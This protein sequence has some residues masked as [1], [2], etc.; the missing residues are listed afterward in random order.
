[1]TV[2][3][4]CEDA[5][6]DKEKKEK[7]KQQQQKPKKWGKKSVSPSYF[8]AV[9]SEEEGRVKRKCGGGGRAGEKEVRVK[10]K[11][12]RPRLLYS[13]DFPKHLN[14]LFRFPAVFV[15]HVTT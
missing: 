13:S 9:L 10:R 7:K 11:G 6:D 5:F 2:R 3:W 15:Y 12:E 8:C 14:F 1:M 4:R